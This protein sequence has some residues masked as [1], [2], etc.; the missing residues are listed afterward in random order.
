MSPERCSK[1]VA[2]VVGFFVVLAAMPLARA[3]DVQRG[4]PT[5]PADDESAVGFRA[6]PPPLPEPD[7]DL[8][9]D[10][11]TVLGTHVDHGGY[12]SPELKLTALNGRSALL[13][14]GE[15]GWII[16]RRLVLGGGGY[17]AATE[18]TAPSILQ[19]PGGNAHLG[20]GYGGFRL[21]GI[22]GSRKLTHV[23]FGV[24]IGG[25]GATASTSD[26][27]YHRSDTFF[28][29]EPDLGAEVNLA[30]HVRLGLGGTYRFV[31]GT[32][33]SGFTSTRLNGPAAMLALR[34]G[35]F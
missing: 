18:V 24:L 19:S 7:A 33:V 20:M 3:D 30:R 25:G 31:G 27:T 29:V 22:V 9:A 6:A 5:T 12:G 8:G 16:G 26:G 2:L 17:G 11:D 15:G 23:T 32:E 10:G 21:G 34:F 28:V 1:P 13:V 14:G 35:V 4:R